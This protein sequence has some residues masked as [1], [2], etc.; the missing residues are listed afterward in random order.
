MFLNFFFKAALERRAPLPQVAADNQ[1]FIK[2]SLENAMALQRAPQ[3]CAEPSVSQNWDLTVMSICY[4]VGGGD[5]G[6]IPCSEIL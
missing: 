4:H 5:V 2:A 1:K 3:F 6:S